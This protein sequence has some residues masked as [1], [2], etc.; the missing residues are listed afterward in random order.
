MARTVA[1]FVITAMVLITVA[2]WLVNTTIT[3]S[4]Q[5]ILMISGLILV[6]GFALFMGVRRAKSLVKKEPIED[7]LSRKHMMKASS[8]SYYISIYFWLF[9]MYISDKIELETHSLIG[10]G[11]L[12]MAV[13]FFL[14]WLGIRIFVFKK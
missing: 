11:I 2:L 1:T 10:A 4:L 7:E 5:E 12:G 9:I 14:S 13:I 6:I 8:L 3:G